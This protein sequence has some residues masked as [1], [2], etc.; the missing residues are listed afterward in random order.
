MLQAIRELKTENDKLQEELKTNEAQWEVQF[1]AQEQW[2]SL[3]ELQQQMADLEAHLAL[4]ESR[5]GT[6]QAISAT[7]EIP[8]GNDGGGQ[9]EPQAKF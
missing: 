6:N 2:A 1:R 8:K 7:R 4:V 9:L 5:G 3:Q